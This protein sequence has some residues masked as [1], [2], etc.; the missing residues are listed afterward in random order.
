MNLIQPALLNVHGPYTYL[1]EGRAHAPTNDETQGHGGTA[2]PQLAA[3]TGLIGSEEATAHVLMQ[4]LPLWLA[5]RWAGRML[6]E[7]R[8]CDQ[9]LR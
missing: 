7:L 1:S 8:L 9:C 6:T 5:S 4:G 2:V 3:G